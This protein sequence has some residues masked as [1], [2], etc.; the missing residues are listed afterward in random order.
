MSTGE[1]TSKC[2]SQRFPLLH[3]T[4]GARYV[5][6]EKHPGTEAGLNMAT[7]KPNICG[8]FS[9]TVT[10]TH[11]QGPGQDPLLF[12]MGSCSQNCH[13]PDKRNKNLL[14]TPR[15]DVSRLSLM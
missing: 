9:E 6:A 12:M 11:G 2:M 13:T 1:K 8:I 5:E 10:A 4:L 3:A 15:H 14:E 7:K